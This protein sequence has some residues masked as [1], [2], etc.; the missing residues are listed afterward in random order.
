MPFSKGFSGNKNGRPAGTKNKRTGTLRT[1][2]SQFL[3]ERFQDIMAAF[4]GLEPQARI[5]VYTDLLQY[6][7]PKL[8]STTIS[9]DLQADLENLTDQELESL[10]NRVLEIEHSQ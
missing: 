10:A 7:L 4:D 1:L 2:I 8:Q 3:E 6:G 9:T 5:K